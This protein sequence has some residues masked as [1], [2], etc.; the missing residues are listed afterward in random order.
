MMDE[1]KET[2][3]GEELTKAIK[4]KR[5]M[6]MVH[7]LV[8]PHFCYFCYLYYVLDLVDN[9]LQSVEGSLFLYALLCYTGVTVLFM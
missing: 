3:A 5:Y 8:I 1:Q 4:L 6:Q 7:L 2:E 9:G